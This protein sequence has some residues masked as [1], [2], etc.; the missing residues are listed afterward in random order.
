MNKVYQRFQVT[1]DKL[2]INERTRSD[3][4][5]VAGVI[6]SLAKSLTL[7][8]FAQ[9]YASDLTCSLRIGGKEVL[10][11]GT[12]VSLML[13]SPLVSRKDTIFE[14]KE[15]DGILAQNS[16]VELEVKDPNGA[17]TSDCKL[18]LYLLLDND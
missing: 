15:S 2:V 9:I 5:R 18:Y 12:H 8:E 7:Q 11:V 17:L 10:P 16:M 4:K 3:F 13:Q 14:I 1:G 6:F